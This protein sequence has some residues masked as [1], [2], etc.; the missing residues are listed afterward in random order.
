MSE[1]LWVAWVVCPKGATMDESALVGSEAKVREVAEKW[2]SEMG[3]SDVYIGRVM[4]M[5]RIRY[6]RPS[7]EPVR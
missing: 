7:W 3:D 2:Y 5:E 1:E 6:V 4:P